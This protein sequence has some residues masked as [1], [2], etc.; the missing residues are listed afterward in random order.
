MA[1]RL[2][3]DER[4]RNAARAG[5]EDGVAGEGGLVGPANAAARVEEGVAAAP[6]PLAGEV[7]PRLRFDKAVLGNGLAVIGEH[8]DGAASVAAGF[9][10]HTGSRDEVKDLSGV[11]HFL[12]HMVF[13]GN[14]RYT[15][16]DINRTFDELGAQYNAFTSEERTVYY[17]A[18]LPE[19]LPQLIDL[20]AEL[21][22]PSLR[23]EDFDVEKKVILEEIAMYEDRPHFHVFDL[24]APR[25]W[26][27]HPL[28]NSV[29]GSRESVGA[30]SRDQMLGYFQGRYSPKNLV[31]AVAGRYDWDA[32][33][34]QAERIAGSWT[35]FEAPR[36]RPVATPATG[37]EGTVD[38]KLN[39]VHVAY[40]APGVAMTDSRRY[41]A[42]VLGYVLGD[43]TGS[44]LYWELVD[45]GLAD[46][47]SLGHEASEDT[48]AFVGYLSTAPERA[49]EV[50]ERYEGVL[51]RAQ[52]EPPTPDEWRRAQRKLA[53][54]LTLRAET[55]LGRL[56]SLGATYQS[57][58]VY[59]SV[60]EVVD[61]VMNAQLETG[62]ELLEGRPFDASFVYTLGPGRRG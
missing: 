30:L 47:A 60:A 24:A 15:A 48:G 2:Y 9:F 36:E 50:I 33:L 39:R 40:Y 34:D 57:L 37:R 3:R 28:G 55:P 23:Q 45:K 54:G 21:M 13:K 4:D 62:I 42:A 26:A 16:E 43:A 5:G 51:R 10:V 49:E 27:G 44:R 7:A 11:S 22:R 59:Q 18:V 31:L 19:R 52:D 35:P 17:G 58:G 56:T 12:E 6:K 1:R 53:S 61:R 41:A 14:E 8:N 38:P 46:S 29:L 20:L 25:F 32:V